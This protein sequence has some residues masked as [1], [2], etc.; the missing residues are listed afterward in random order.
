MPCVDPS[1]SW[2]RISSG[3][4]C[5]FAITSWNPCPA[6]SSAA[7]IIALMRRGGYRPGCTDLIRLP[8]MDLDEYRELN[9]RTWEAMAPGWEGWRPWHWDTTKVVGQ[10]L[11]EKLRPEE[12]Q[13]IL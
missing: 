1:P 12:G 10:K 6:R 5:M 7:R 8:P 9:L 2:S 13:T 3:N 4:Q 11:V